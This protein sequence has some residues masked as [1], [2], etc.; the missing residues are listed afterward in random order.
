MMKCGS[1]GADL[2]AVAG[3]LQL[4][5]ECVGPYVANVR[6][7]LE[8]AV[9]G[10]ILI[11]GEAAGV[12]DAAR[13]R[14]LEELLL[15]APLGDFVTASQAAEML[16][17]SR[18]ALHKNRRVRNG[19]I[20]HVRFGE[21]TLYLRQS[22]DLFK[23]LGDGR[24]PLFT[25]EGTMLAEVDQYTDSEALNSTNSEPYERDFERIAHWFSEGFEETLCEQ[26]SSYV[27]GRSAA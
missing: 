18:Q 8:C 6:E 11:P 3:P 13:Q 2:I 20:F 12:V 26:G 5:D 16:G 27:E 10:E 15:A 4:S 23:E 24:F 19:F 21:N 22:V 14:R 9:C 17:V 25:G 7:Y 1:C